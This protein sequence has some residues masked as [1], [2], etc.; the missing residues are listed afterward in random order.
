M[1]CK[2]IDMP[3]RNLSI[4]NILHV[5]ICIYYKLYIKSTKILNAFLTHRFL[6]YIF[7]NLDISKKI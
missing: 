3:Q 1:Y 6:K 7:F 5:I 4:I 2:V